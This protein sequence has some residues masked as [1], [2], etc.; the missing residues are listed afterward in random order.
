LHQTTKGEFHNDSNSSLIIT[1][2]NDDDFINATRNLT[3]TDS[4]EEFDEIEY[5]T[6]T[7]RMF[8]SIRQSFGLS[9]HHMAMVLNIPVSKVVGFEKGIEVDN[10]HGIRKF[11]ETYLYQLV[12]NYSG[13]NDETKD[14]MNQCKTALEATERKLIK[15][16]YVQLSSVECLTERIDGNKHRNLDI[17]EY[18]EEL[19]T[20]VTGQLPMAL[21]TIT[22][23]I[24]ITDIGITRAKLEDLS[25]DDDEVIAA[26]RFLGEIDTDAEGIEKHYPL[27]NLVDCTE[28]GIDS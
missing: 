9:S 18:I 27:A 13:F 20:E 24:R 8:K 12:R 17:E 19:Y 5:F 6:E 3:A 14:C 10:G 26:A 1:S 25:L 4:G 21:Q 23:L 7:G 28:Y 2:N 22:R 11:Y 15:R 16:F